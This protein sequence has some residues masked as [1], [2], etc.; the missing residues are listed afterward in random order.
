MAELLYLSADYQQKLITGGNE[1]AGSTA[2]WILVGD[3]RVYE[4]NRKLSDA[5]D[6]VALEISL[7][8]ISSLYFC[9]VQARDAGQ[10]VF[11]SDE[12]ASTAIDTLGNRLKGEPYRTVH[13]VIFICFQMEEKTGL[14]EL[15]KK[16]SELIN[17]AE[18]SFRIN[19]VNQAALYRVFARR[20][21]SHAEVSASPHLTVAKMNESVF[22]FGELVREVQAHARELASS[23]SD[24]TSEL[25]A[26]VQSLFREWGNK[27]SVALDEIRHAREQ[28]SALQHEVEGDRDRLRDEILERIEQLRV[29]AELFTQRIPEGGVPVQLPGTVLKL[30]SEEIAKAVKLHSGLDEKDL[31]RIKAKLSEQDE[32]PAGELVSYGDNGAARRAKKKG[33]GAASE[34][35]GQREKAHLIRFGVSKPWVF[36][37]LSLFLLA[38]VL[39]T[40]FFRGV[41][42]GLFFN[43]AQ[44]QNAE[45]GILDKNRTIATLE[46]HVKKLTLK[47]HENEVQDSFV[48]DYLCGIAILKELLLEKEN[49]GCKKSTFT[50]KIQKF[51]GDKDKH[52]VWDEGSI[53]IF[54]GK[55]HPLLPVKVK[56]KDKYCNKENFWS[57]CAVPLT[58]C[59]DLQI[60]VMS[61][62]DQGAK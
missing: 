30:I 49:Q 16:F 19:N 6:Q 45:Q 7:K 8:Q 4:D 40:P 3:I 10:V 11:K 61:P 55:V 2:I 26:S 32:E 15:T 46:N 25:L 56:W 43:S 35:S 51:L 48:K 50:K 34:A 44:S 60:T 28:F 58:F 14:F 42:T 29:A 24:S 1:F 27:Y 18:R 62:Y 41:F 23:A 31:E 20:A 21:I 39:L 36:V 53:K 52:C 13:D 9:V 37:G 54:A 33:I 59:K 57:G 22:L 17:A 5:R 47:I 38:L 12:L